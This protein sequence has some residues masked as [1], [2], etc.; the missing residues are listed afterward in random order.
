MPASCRFAMAVHVLT[1]L[2]Y[3]EGDRMSSALLA[4]SVNT[5]PVIIR[6]LLLALQ[7]AKLVDTCKGAG[8]GSRLNYA[9]KRINMA[10]VY[11]AVE[12]ADP[13]KNPRR[14]PN[15]DCPVGQCMRQ[16]MEKIFVSAENALERDLEKTTLADVIE[17]VKASCGCDKKAS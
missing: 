1:L 6:R 2:A 15:E 4:G 11:R 8:A 5:N 16:E 10:Q 12:A 3:K 17:A 7:R 9:P 13:F 14:K